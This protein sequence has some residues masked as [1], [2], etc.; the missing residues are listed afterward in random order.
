M[1][2]ANKV[3]IIQL[4]CPELLC[5]GLDRQDKHGSERNLLDEN[6]RIR[7]LMQKNGNTALLRKKVQE[8]VTQVREYREY[9][10]S[11]IGLVGINRSPSCGIETTSIDGK[12]E[13]GRGVFMQVIAEELQ[14]ENLELKMVG[15]KTS[16][17]EESLETVR[18]LLKD[19][20]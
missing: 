6:T 20:V 5:L 14:K 1:F 18:Q 11:I 16:K 7:K 8:V 10:F 9:G 17:I 15:V 13:P 19:C 12:E 3:G 2:M 4:P